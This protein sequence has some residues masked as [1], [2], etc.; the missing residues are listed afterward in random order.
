MTTMHCRTKKNQ[1][2]KFQIFATHL[3]D[4]FN[5]LKRTCSKIRVLKLH[6][7]LPIMDPPCPLVDRG[8]LNGK[9]IWV[10]YRK[11]LV[12]TNYSHLYRYV[13]MRY[14]FHD[15]FHVFRDFNILSKWNHNIIRIFIVFRL[16]RLNSTVW[17][18]KNAGSTLEYINCDRLL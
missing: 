16:F 17:T 7:S 10:H 18:I 13:K 3:L 5:N 8:P 4:N 12:F 11:L 9:W 6:I 14:S 15:E 2:I 1:A